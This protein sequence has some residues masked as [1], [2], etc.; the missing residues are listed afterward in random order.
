MGFDLLV[1]LEFSV[2][3]KTGAPY[4]W[5]GTYE[6]GLLRIPVQ[7]SDYIVPEQYRKYLQQRGRI[8][9][10][11]IK[12]FATNIYNSTAEEFLENYPQWS[13][14]KEYMD[15]ADTSDLV[16]HNEFKEFLKWAVEKNCFMIR[17]SY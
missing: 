10:Q 6:T 13:Q 15:D 9:H 17:W 2:D 3:P 11:Y 14:V 12:G 16:C 8:F 4:V 5:G 1:Q 7:L